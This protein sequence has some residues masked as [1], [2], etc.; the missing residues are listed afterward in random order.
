MKK[1]SFLKKLDWILIFSV[2]FLSIFGLIEIWSASR[3]NYLNF[4]KQIFFVFLGFLL[5]IFFSFFDWRFLRENP[6]FLLFLYFLSLFFLLGLFFFAP[7]IRGTKTWYRILFFSFDPSELAKISLLLI[8]ARYFSLKHP[9][10]YN[11]SHIFFSFLYFFLPG[12]LIFF[13]PNLGTFLILLFLWF[14]ILIF[15]GIKLRHFFLLCVIFLFIFIFSFDKVLK[16][17]Q[18]ERILTFIF[19]QK[20]DPL[21]QGWSQKQSLI[22]IGSGGFFGKGLKKGSQTQMGFLPEPQGDFIFSAIAEEM[23]FFGILCLFFLYFVLFFR[24]LKMAFSFSSNF[25]K[26][27]SMGF[28]A[29][30]VCQTSMHLASNLKLSPVIGITLPFVGY[31]GSNLLANFILLGI[32]Q[33]MKINE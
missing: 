9:Q 27:F 30:L 32:L 19:P 17:Y 16:P 4:Q 22:A 5:M 15:S 6:S 25:A 21:K 1:I 2:L 26:L 33:S 14:S 12:I 7:L 18:R 29:I 13:Q 24:I 28:L 11:L 20:A 10:I 31:G 8:L 3:G 23:G